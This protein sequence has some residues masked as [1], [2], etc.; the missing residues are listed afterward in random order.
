MTFKEYLQDLDISNDTKGPEAIVFSVIAACRP[1][2]TYRE[3]SL[4]FAD[5]PVI[6]DTFESL[7][8]AY[9]S[10]LDRRNYEREHAGPVPVSVI[11]GRVLKHIAEQIKRNGYE[12]NTND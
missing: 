1:D 6:R 4:I 9:E 8:Y 2:I 3:A 7:W 12:T 5:V 11:T 10:E